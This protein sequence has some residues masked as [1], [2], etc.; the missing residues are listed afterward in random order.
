MTTVSTLQVTTFQVGHRGLAPTASPIQHQGQR[1]FPTNGIDRRQT[2]R[3]PCE[4]VSSFIT[5]V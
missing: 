2:A 1:Q 3:R 4:F 5:V